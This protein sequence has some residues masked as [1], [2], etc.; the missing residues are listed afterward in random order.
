MEN[1]L[2]RLSMP[3]HV[4]M[5]KNK[6]IVQNRRYSTLF[7]GHFKLPLSGKKYKYIMDNIAYEP[8]ERFSTAGGE[9]W[10]YNDGTIPLTEKDIDHTL[11]R[12]Y[13]NR[14]TSLLELCDGVAYADNNPLMK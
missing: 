11:L 8:D 4:I 9:F 13:Y 5:E 7:E 14:L 2:F 6:I 1:W 10:L 12:D 3:Y